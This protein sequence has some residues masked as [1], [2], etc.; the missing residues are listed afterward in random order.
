MSI[1]NMQ[2]NGSRGFTF[3]EVLVAVAVIAILSTV[4]YASLGEARKKARDTERKTSIENLQVAFRIN[5]DESGTYPTTGHTL[6]TIIGEGGALDATLLPYMTAVVKDPSG[7]VSDTT[8][9]YVYDS[10]FT[11]GGT[12]R[13]VLYAKS[14][15]RSGNSNWS[16][17]CGGTLPGTYTYGVILQ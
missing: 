17:V 5:K 10:D 3:V 7:S 9:E 8:Y 13:I 2:K 4:A 16:T 11:C 6:G 12:S 1:F 14:M 15:E